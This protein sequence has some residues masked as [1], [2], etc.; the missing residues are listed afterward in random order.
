M[1]KIDHTYMSA[2]EMESGRFFDEREEKDFGRRKSEG[3]EQGLFSVVGIVYYATRAG[4]ARLSTFRAS[5]NRH[6]RQ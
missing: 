3:I 1:L 6:T 2:T 4:S 5:R